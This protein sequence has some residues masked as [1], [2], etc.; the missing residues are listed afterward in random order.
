MFDPLIVL[1]CL[2][3]RLPPRIP[4][5]PRKHSP[6]F[7]SPLNLL[8]ISLG[9]QGLGLEFR[10]QGTGYS[11]LTSLGHS[12]LPSVLPTHHPP[13]SSLL[14]ALLIR[15]FKLIQL[16]SSYCADSVNKENNP[17]LVVEI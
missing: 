6:G 11:V 9:F 4:A 5:D 16:F 13:P 7:G 15:F 3:R 10:G 12:L 8:T 2:A 14:S 17:M 1:G